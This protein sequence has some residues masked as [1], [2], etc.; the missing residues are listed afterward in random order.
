MHVKSEYL[1]TCA[2]TPNP[3]QDNKLQ[4]SPR[5]ARLK[6]LLFGLLIRLT[7]TYVNLTNWILCSEAFNLYATKKEAW[8]AS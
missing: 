6:I 7:D 1:Q 4:H 5:K 2:A 3:L 8:W